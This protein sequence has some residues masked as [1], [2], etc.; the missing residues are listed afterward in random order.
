MWLRTMQ[1]HQISSLQLYLL[2]IL[3]CIAKLLDVVMVDDLICYADSIMF[4]ELSCF[5][6][7]YILAYKSLSHIIRPLKIESVCGPKS[8]NHV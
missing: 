8:L 6:L 4:V 1:T 3:V 2:S 7:L 5:K